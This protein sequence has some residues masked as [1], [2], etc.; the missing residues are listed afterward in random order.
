MMIL[1]PSDIYLLFT[2]SMM[3]QSVYHFIAANVVMLYF[4][5]FNDDPHFVLSM[6]VK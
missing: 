1:P 6:G 5:G 4:D 2:N 3:L